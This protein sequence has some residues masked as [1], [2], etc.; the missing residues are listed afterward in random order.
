MGRGGDLKA[1]LTEAL[2]RASGLA[3]LGP[4]EPASEELRRFA[5]AAH[6]LVTRVEPPKDIALVTLLRWI[7]Q[8]RGV[9]FHGSGRNDLTTLEP[10]RL[11]RDSMPFGDQQA[12]FAA[13]DPVCAIYF[14]TLRRGNGFRSTRNGSL[15]IPGGGLYPRWYFFSHNEDA[16]RANRF[17][18]G[19]LYLLPPDSFRP[20][21]SRWG[22]LDAGQWASPTAVTPIVRVAV[23]AADFPFADRVH[24]HRVDESML[25]TYLRASRFGRRIL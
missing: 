20:E 15:G 6:E 7:V 12:V 18:D 23:S 22:V 24:E 4:V 11:T 19:W 1:W 21:P 16:D 5:E 25:R 14:A 10:I 3:S 17:G 8:E 2:L 13:S 9:L